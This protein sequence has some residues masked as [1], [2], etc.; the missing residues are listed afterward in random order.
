MNEREEACKIRDQQW[1]MAY[2]NV[3][4]YSICGHIGLLCMHFCMYCLCLFSMCARC[5]CASHVLPS[6]V[7]SFCPVPFR[8][9]A[10]QSVPTSLRNISNR[11]DVVC[12]VSN[13]NRVLPSTDRSFSIYKRACNIHIDMIFKLYKYYLFRVYWNIASQVWFIP[14]LSIAFCVC[15]VHIN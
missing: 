2:M 5:A 1:A 11:I 15:R 7:Y 9:S 4:M 10:S 12:L 13:W 14:I 8:Q 3:C 6:P